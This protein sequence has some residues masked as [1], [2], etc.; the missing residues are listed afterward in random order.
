V[1]LLKQ[2]ASGP[3]PFVFTSKDNTQKDL[4]H[5]KAM[6]DLRWIDAAFQETQSGFGVLEA[7]VYRITE[8]GE[9]VLRE[10]KPLVK[11]G[12]LATDLVRSTVF[13]AA[14]VALATVGLLLVGIAQCRDSR[15]VPDLG[16]SATPSPTIFQQLPEQSAPPKETSASISGAEST[17]TP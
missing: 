16:H 7:H 11:V 17:S 15:S 10:D 13:W 3:L 1:K 12:Y 5:L 4:L 14:I 2:L 8:I 6:A 9:A